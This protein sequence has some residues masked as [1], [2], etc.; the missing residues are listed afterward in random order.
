ML[1]LFTAPTRSA[2]KELREK[3]T[4]ISKSKNFTAKTEYQNLKAPSNNVK[5]QS[6]KT[7]TTLHSLLQFLLNIQQMHFFN[8]TRQHVDEENE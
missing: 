6:V 2:V 1:R 7:L 8:E 4:K 3:K 5:M